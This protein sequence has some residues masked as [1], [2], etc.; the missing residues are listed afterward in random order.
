MEKISIMLNTELNGIK[1][2]TILQL[3]VDSDG[4]PVQKYWR[5]RLKDSLID[6]CLTVLEFKN[7]ENI[8]E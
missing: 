8:G 7:N 2:G 4:I 3:D 6:N 1:S 5:K